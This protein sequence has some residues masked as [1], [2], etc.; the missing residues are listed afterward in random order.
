ME[1]LREMMEMRVWALYYGVFSRDYD[2]REL[3]TR[4]DRVKKVISEYTD[5]Q[6]LSVYDT[7]KRENV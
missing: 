5:R 3:N 6:L 1:N 7:L 4:M 2:G